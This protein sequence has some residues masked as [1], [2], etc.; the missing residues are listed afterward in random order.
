[1]TGWTRDAVLRAAADWV[2]TPEGT[3]EHETDDYRLVAFPDWVSQPAQVVRCRASSAEKVVEAVTARARSWGL[4]RVAWRV[5]E[6][7]APASLEAF[8]RE[9]GAALEET[10]DVLAGD[11]TAG[12]VDPGPVDGVRAALVEDEAALWASA[13]VAAEVWGDAPPDPG[14]LASD[15]AALATP[16]RERGDFR[17]V[18]YVDGQP[19]GSAGC[20]LADGGVARMWG[21][22]TLPGAR[23]RGVYRAMLAL[24]TSVAREHGATLALVKGRVATSAPILRRLGFTSYGQERVYTLP[25]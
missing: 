22:A 4:D 9:A 16:L 11:L 7:T 20:T 25:L 10:L 23:G 13:T 1:M 5:A 15:L 12:P 14:R 19:A 18:G 8:L 3:R 6:D 17:V 2:W 24:R 21:A